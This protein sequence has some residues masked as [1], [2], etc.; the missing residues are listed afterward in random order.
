M[1][2]RGIALGEA[3]SLALDR[4]YVQH[5]RAVHLLDLQQHVDQRGQV[6]AVDRSHRQQ[7]ELLEPRVLGHCIFGYLAEAVIH[8]ADQRPAGQ[9]PDNVLGCAFHLAVSG[10]DA[11]TIEIGGQR[12]LG[13]SDRHAVI[14]EDDKELA[15]EGAG[16]VH[17]LHR[18]AVDDRRIADQGDHAAPLGVGL[19]IE[20]FVVQ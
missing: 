3:V 14:V 15:F 1:E 9:M 12:T 20:R 19:R 17:A 16:V 2:R 10:V 6:V 4:V 8:L 7:P 18:H 5:H 13:V 11:D